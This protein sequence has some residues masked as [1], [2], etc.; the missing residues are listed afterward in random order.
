MS[1][2]TNTKNELIR[3]RVDGQTKAQAEAVLDSIGLSMSE[4]VRLFAKQIALRN[5][6]PLELKVPNS[7][8]R[9]AL[10]DSE[11][12]QKLEEIDNISELFD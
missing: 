9:Q 7:L 3:A 2:I 5:E 6:F 11:T 12:P 10:T 8:T 4:A 1:E